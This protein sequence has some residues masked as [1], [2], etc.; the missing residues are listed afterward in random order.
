MSPSEC[1]E[2]IAST[3]SSDGSPRPRWRLC[4]GLCEEEP[5][6]RRSCRPGRLSL[7]ALARLLCPF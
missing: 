5:W 4:V 7:V 6:A 2:N 3:T 1:A